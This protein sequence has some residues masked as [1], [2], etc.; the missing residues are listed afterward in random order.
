MSSTRRIV[1][2]G[3]PVAGLTVFAALALA[4]SPA[5]A[6]TEDTAA[7]PAVMTTCD[8]RDDKCGY[9]TAGPASTTPGRGHNGYGTVSPTPTGPTTT[10]PTRPTPG[11]STTPTGGVHT[12]PPTP[13]SSVTVQGTVTPSASHPGGVSAGHALPV[14]GAPMGAV[15]SLGALMVAGGVLSV[16]YSRRRRDA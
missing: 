10:V 13:T 7:R 8:S 5:T 9:P 14:T 4:G 15:V 2:A 12:V 16:W 11:T 6:S 1:T 3:L